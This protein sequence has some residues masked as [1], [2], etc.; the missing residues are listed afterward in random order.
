MGRILVLLS[1]I[2]SLAGCHPADRVTSAS[3]P[4]VDGPFTLTLSDAPAVSTTTALANTAGWER[5]NATFYHLW[6][7]A[8]ADSDGD[9]TGDLPGITAKINANYFTD[10]GI[11]A[12]WLSPIFE[13][14]TLVASAS[15]KHGYDTTDYDTVAPLFGTEANL[16]ALLDAAHGKNIRVIFDFVPNHTSNDHLWFSSASGKSDWYVWKSSRPSGWTG[17]DSSTD[18]YSGSSGYYYGV[19][20][21]GM[22][23]LN[24][25]NAAVRNEMAS[26]AARW[27]NFGFDG[28]RIDAVKYLFEGA[29]GDYW[30]DQDDTYFWFQALRSQVVDPYAG[31]GSAK[32]MVSENWISDT[33]NLISYLKKDGTNAF[34]MTFDFDWAGT[35]NGNLYGYGTA[36]NVSALQYELVTR[37][38]LLPSGTTF[39]AFQSNHDNVASRPATALSGA[40][41]GARLMLA[42]GLT[43]LGKSVPFIYYG[44]EIGM[45]GAS[46]N[47]I[48]LRQAFNWTQEATLAADPNSLWTWHSQILKLRAVSPAWTDPSIAPV[49]V[50]S[51][52]PSSMATGLLAYLVTGTGG[53]R[54]LVVANLSSSAV[55]SVTLG[56]SNPSL[57]KT[58]LGAGDP[59]VGT[60]SVTLSSLPAF[61]LRVI[62]L[63][64]ASPTVVRATDADG[65]TFTPSPL[66]YPTLYLRGT[67]NSW[68]TTALTDLGS[69][70]FSASFTNGST[71]ATVQFKFGSAD[72]ASSLGYSDLSYDSTQGGLSSGLFSTTGSYGNI[73]FTADANSS[74]TIHLQENFSAW[75]GTY[76]VVK[77]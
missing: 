54:A 1:L 38:N 70:H 56:V 50:A 32:F 10:L 61:G 43:V 21:S 3:G 72:W 67:M 42:A 39:G 19:F 58:V 22:P 16:R 76:W 77:S 74:Y 37:P 75:G 62:A 64:E 51:A 25:R 11:N 40:N 33:D 8:F 52:T 63:D 24:Y 60:S 23:D 36:S 69:G 65:S 9:G 49:T 5:Q 6:V 20:G 73:V 15:N 2:L 4:L 35:V 27:L 30:K 28:M 7:S 34:N 46:G 14:G 17:F 18:W 41:Q 45:Q 55:S 12:L 68:S 31:L 44:N 29:S 47:D 53:Q 66:T 59:V 57:A 48:N 26:V 71:A 13:A